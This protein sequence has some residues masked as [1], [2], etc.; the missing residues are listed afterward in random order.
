MPRQQTHKK[1][2]ADKRTRKVPSKHREVVRG[3]ETSTSTRKC[4]YTP[5]L[6]K[7]TACTVSQMPRTEK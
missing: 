3:I 2:S 6:L 1:S 4:A 7:T 5:Y